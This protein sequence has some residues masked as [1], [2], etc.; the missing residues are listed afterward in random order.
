MKTPT[1]S[2]RSLTRTKPD[3]TYQKLPKDSPKNWPQERALPGLRFRLT[4]DLQNTLP[5][6]AERVDWP[7]WRADTTTNTNHKRAT[8]TCGFNGRLGAAE[9]RVRPKSHP[10]FRHAKT[11]YTGW[12]HRHKVTSRLGGKQIW[13]QAYARVIRQRAQKIRLERS[14]KEPDDEATVS[15]SGESQRQPITPCR[16]E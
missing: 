3:T 12:D 9:L 2:W 6:Q 11:I 13:R 5:K 4:G 8:P 15:A 10:W 7:L 14:H 16:K 1:N